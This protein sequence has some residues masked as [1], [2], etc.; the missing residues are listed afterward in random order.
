[1]ALHQD[2]GCA[3]RH[4]GRRAE[5]EEAPTRLGRSLS[6]QRDAIGTGYTLRQ[7]NSLPPCS[8]QKPN[9]IRQAKVGPFEHG[10]KGDIALGCHYELR[11]HGYDVM[12]RA[13]SDEFADGYQ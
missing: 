3:L 12:R 6:N 8:P 2:M 1:M 11:V 5:K 10:A 13:P 9:A 4:T 7:R